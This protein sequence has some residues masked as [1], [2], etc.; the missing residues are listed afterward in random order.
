MRGRTAYWL[1]AAVLVGGIAMAAGL[2]PRTPERGADATTSPRPEAERSALESDRALVAWSGSRSAIDTPQ[3]SRADSEFIWKALWARH[4]GDRAEENATGAALFPVVDFDR[5]TVVA[6]FGGTGLNS[7]GYRIESIDDNEERVRVR[8]VESTFQTAGPRGGGVS[9]T[10]YGIFILPDTDLPI[11]LE[12]PAPHL[13]DEP[14]RWVERAKL[15]VN[16]REW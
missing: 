3:V 6:I 14:I 1:G 13:K 11:V 7:R 10:P 2:V 4:R 16:A 15:E 12:E 8:I 5:C 9:V